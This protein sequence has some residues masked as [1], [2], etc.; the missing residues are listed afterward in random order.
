MK[1]TTNERE[2]VRGYASPL[3]C[4]RLAIPPSTLSMWANRGLVVATLLGATGRRST[5]YWTPEDYVLIRIVKA[6]RDAGGPYEVIAAAKTV[7]E[8]AWDRLDDDHHLYWDGQDLL[9]VSR[10]GQIQSRLQR[11]GQ[12]L[13]HVVATPL[14][15]WHD[16]AVRNATLYLA[17]D[18]EN[19]RRRREGILHSRSSRA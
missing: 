12:L 4:E 6:L 13:L 9:E 1:T 15:Q 10:W 3:V 16:D 8:G 17:S 14:Q 11:P 5:R 19:L 7:V 18:L 2:A